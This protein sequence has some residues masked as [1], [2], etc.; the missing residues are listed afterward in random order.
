MMFALA[1]PL[2]AWAS[3]TPSMYG[4]SMKS[5][6]VTIDMT[7]GKMTELGTEHSEE[8]EAQELSAI[9]AKRAPPAAAIAG[10]AAACA[11]P[12]GYCFAVDDCSQMVAG[13]ADPLAVA[14]YLYGVE[15]ETGKLFGKK[16][17]LCSMEPGPKTNPQQCPWS[18]ELA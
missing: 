15:L 3:S 18:I 12:Y 16:V 17:P 4:V 10:H 14:A 13:G 2:L 6:L 7:S 1:A 9:D 8:L 11:D 5:S